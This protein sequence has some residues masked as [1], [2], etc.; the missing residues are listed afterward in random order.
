MKWGADE[1]LSLPQAL[2]SV[3]SR[4]VAVL[5]DA[6]GSLAQSAGQLVVGGVADLC[7]FD[8]DAVWQ[9]QP[10]G[11]RSQGKYTP[12]DFGVTGAALPGR[13][14]ATLVAGTVAYQSQ[15]AA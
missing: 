1:G 11:L 2:Q 9:V 5:G 3:T 7:V 14:Q 8:P 6:L 4:P 13:V 12:F 15:P 10:G